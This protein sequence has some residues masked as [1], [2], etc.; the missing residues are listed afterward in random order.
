M[1]TNN[2]WESSTTGESWSPALSLGA[3]GIAPWVNVSS[4]NSASP[5][6]RGEFNV[7]GNPESAIVTVHT[8]SYFELY[9]NGQKAGDDVLT[10][11]VSD[12]KT[13]TFTVT[14][15]VAHLLTPGVNC[16]GLWM[17]EGWSDRIAVRAQLDGVAGGVPFTFSTGPAWKSRPSGYSHIGGWSWGNFGGERIE[18]AAHLPNWSLPGID[19]SSWSTVVAATAP[20]GPPANHDTPLNRIGEV[21]LA[22]EITTLAQGRYVIDFGTNL[23]GWL[24]LKFPPL[25]PGQLVRLHFA[26]NV[27]PDGIQASPIG[28]I[29]VSTN[30]CVSFP[31]IG[32]GNNLYQTYNQVSE[33]VS[34]GGANEEFCHK[35]NYAG[36]RYVVIE[37]LTTAPILADATAMLVESD[38]EDAGAFESSDPL[39][40]RIH[41]VNRWT[42]RCLNLG[43]YYVDCP[44]RE[45]MG[46][47]DGQVALQGMMMNF[48]TAN[49]YSKWAQDWRLAL[50]KKNEALAYIAPPFEPTG[51][52]PPWPGGIARIPWQHY[53]HYG[54]PAILEENIDAARSYCEYLDGRSTN[55]VLRNWGGG[56]SFIGD[57]VAPGRGMDTGNWPNQQM[58]E[59]FCNNYRVHL[60]QLVEKMATALGRTNE[61]QHARQR[62]EAISTAVHAAFFDAANN[63]YVIDEQIYYAFPLMVGLTPAEHR[64]AVLENL[65]RCIVQKNNGH[66][67]TG[68]L[69]TMVLMEYLNDIGRDDLVLNIYQKKTYPSWGYMVEQGATTLWEQWNGYWSQIHSCFTSADNWLYQGLAGI[70]PDPA[71]PGFKKVIIRPA[72]V[73]DVTWVNTRHDGPYGRIINHW[74]RDGANVTLQ[75]TIPPN[76]TAEVHVPAS[77][78][79]EVTESGNP[80][81]TAP[82]VEFLR[83]EN[84]HA[85]FAVGAGTYQFTGTLPV[86]L[87]PV[88][89]V[90]AGSPLA[91][92]FSGSQTISA[93]LLGGI[94]QAP[95]T[96]NAATHPAWFTSPGS[97]LVMPE[98]RTWNN[99]ANTGKW[100]AS[101][102]NWS[103]Q[104]W[105]P[106]ATATIAHSATASNI[107]LEHDQTASAVSIGNGGNNL[108][109]TFTGPGSLTAG[110]L[111]I[112]GA[113]GNEQASM[114][115]TLFDHANITI[116]GDLGLGR[117]GLVISGNSIVSTKRLG[118]TGIG[119]VSS[120]DWGTLTLQDNA[121]LT[122]AD[123]ILANTTAWGVRLNGGTLTT[124]GINYGPHAFRT[125]LTG[126]FF[127]ST[128]VRA[129]QDNPAFLSF[130]GG[131]YSPPVVQSGGARIDTN[132]HTITLGLALTGPGSLTKL[133]A[134]T[135]KLAE[136]H[137]HQGGTNVASGTLEVTGTLGS[138]DLSVSNGA[139]AE[140]KNSASTIADTAAVRLTGSGRIHLAAG[141][142]ESVAQLHIDGLLRMS[143][144]WNATRDPLHFSGPGNLVVTSGG[145]PTPAEAW[146]FQHFSTY[147]NSGNSADEADSDNDGA[148]NLLERAL[149]SNPKAGDTTSKPILNP[150]GPN[151][152]FNYT[153]AKAATD[154]VID[155]E[156][157]PDLIPTTWRIATPTDGTHTL[158]DDT[159]PEIQTWRFNATT[160][161]SRMF[162]RLRVR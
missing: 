39:L 93:L 123:G 130:T 42:Q 141:V 62:A 33:F 83:M 14:Y 29:S 151:F 108:V 30:S 16:L 114:P 63:R 126:L 99:A 100:N 43:S 94:L 115:N 57:W 153:R 53:L 156:V 118:G 104:A 106:G 22:K 15:D 75:V 58:T 65:V 10:P 26:D 41:Q 77:A 109:Y 36:F 142:S 3:Y 66:L 102:A 60:W 78:V 80:A 21:I 101:D 81:A 132:G 6:L 107:S 111:T 129:N 113:G 125:S 23:T 110:S 152:S 97:L 56:W 1:V 51:G 55:D 46:Y 82:G 13:R 137:T 38:L 160:G 92:D 135:L 68:M 88:V 85:V 105:S 91:L 4:V 140:L 5:W 69:G 49:F 45:R 96:Y 8:H 73:G 138:G 34:A 37:G 25:S 128:L 134:G 54:N 84:R 61:A 145:P 35:F 71:Q 148:S 70:R 87:G 112:Q 127:N 7:T 155:L 89:E 159:L 136:T 59:F 149:G 74:T 154:L 24:C 17:S 144:T 64:P 20:A 52:G 12:P 2:T 98:A 31:R 50:E 90:P 72:V 95:G 103:G 158:T 27:F 139:V 157:S 120:A 162:Y 40:N 124:K 48:N 67:D 119:S 131:D 116:S 9:V 121:Q 146:R 32:G 161:A 150:G 47:G 122:V 28:N 11:A 86:T 18:A 143:G 76:S 44:H 79:G 147:N 19:T 117:A 133:G